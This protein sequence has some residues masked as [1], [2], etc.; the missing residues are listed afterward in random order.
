V[1]FRENITIHKVLY[2]IGT[3]E[4]FDGGKCWS[5]GLFLI[6]AAVTKLHNLAVGVCTWYPRPRAIFV[7]TSGKAEPDSAS[8]ALV[9]DASIAISSGCTGSSFPPPFL[10]Y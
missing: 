3:L 7:A 1:L 4:E 2:R 6:V 8:L 9:S 10:R 5:E